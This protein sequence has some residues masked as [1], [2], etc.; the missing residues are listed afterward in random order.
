ME[1][2]MRKADL[3]NFVI[4]ELNSIWD[5]KRDDLY[6]ENIISTLL[7]MS[8]ENDN[9]QYKENAENDELVPLMPEPKMHISLEEEPRML[10]QEEEESEDASETKIR[11]KIDQLP[12]SQMDD[13]L[14]SPKDCLKTIPEKGD[15]MISKEESSAEADNL[16]QARELMRGVETSDRNIQVINPQNLKRNDVVLK[17]ILRSMRRFF[18]NKFLAITKFKKTEKQL[19][20]RKEN[21]VKCVKELIPQL[22]LPEGLANYEFYYLAL[23]YPSELKKVLNDAKNTSKQQGNAV[24][25]T[26]N[27]VK[28][29][30]SVLNR[31]SK[32]IFNSFMEIPEIAFLVQH[33]LRENTEK[34]D[35]IVGFENWV[36]LLEEKSKGVTEAFNKNPKSFASNPFWIKK[37]L[38]IFQ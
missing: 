22:N 14:S 15:E 6:D 26:L 18:W 20:V 10:F 25:Q 5:T 36:S 27:I 19:K 32:K 31:F 2:S 37:P 23:A 29:F 12:D 1:E 13:H 28:M 16:E 35:H 24:S 9:D 21:L 3:S 4:S 30:E 17:S 33:F 7:R 11:I 34:L 8:E 38:F